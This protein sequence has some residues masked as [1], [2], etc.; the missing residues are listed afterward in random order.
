MHPADRLRG[1]ASTTLEGRRIVLG[2]S[3]SIAAV[4]TVELAREL[5]R[6]GA[7]VQA[8]MTDAARGIVHPD[9]LA[10]A[11]GRDV[12]TRLTGDVEHVT[13][14][15]ED[16][17][18]D[19]LLLAPATAN[20]LAKVA[21][22]IDDTP[23]TSC[24]SVALSHLPILA[25]PAMHGTME[26]NPAVQEAV[27]KLEAWG[28]GLVAPV[29]EETK[30]K[31]A[32]VETIAA[33][34][35]RAL[36][37]GDLAGRRVLVVTGGTAE[38]V[39]DVRTLG[40]VATGRTGYALAEAAFRRG[41][42]V[43]VWAGTGTQTPP[44]HLPIQRFTTLDDLLELVPEAAGFD[45]VL[46]PAALAD[47]RPARNEGKVPSGRDDAAIDLEPAPKVLPEI[48]EVCD[49]TVVGFKL[50]TDVDDAELLERAEARRK[51]HDLDAIVA[52]RLADADPDRR[53]V[54]VLTAEDRTEIEGPLAEVADRILT[55]VA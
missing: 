34:V 10:F 47:Y 18:G 39:D 42:D 21:A 6:L 52:N 13:L 12:V 22:G 49:G 41:A 55:E 37:P 25:A 17:W 9:S 2:I 31:L 8:V 45:L 19:L 24:A 43:T 3:G 16:G 29:R 33:H 23:V 53:R 7:E 36:G 5:I 26:D 28:V 20:T 35:E 50:E 51:E 4:K 38:P 27:G 32:D 11:T 15:G 30:A 14:C 48:R 44:D 54:H 40:N 46:C 1:T